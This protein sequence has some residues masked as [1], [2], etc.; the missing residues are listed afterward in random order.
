MSKG[1]IFSASVCSHVIKYKH[2]YR[3]PLIPSFLSS[4]LHARE[5]D[6]GEAQGRGYEGAQGGE[7]LSVV[8]ALVRAVMHVGHS[9]LRLFFCLDLSALFC[10][11]SAPQ[12]ALSFPCRLCLDTLCLS[13]CSVVAPRRETTKVDRGKRPVRVTE[14]I[15]R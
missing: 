11:A 8:L 14:T 2:Q 15:C 9:D 13:P 6:G 12:V 7:M 10:S 3:I 1:D 5:R 4:S